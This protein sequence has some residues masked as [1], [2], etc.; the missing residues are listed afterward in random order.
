MLKRMLSP[1]RGEVR[2]QDADPVVEAATVDPHQPKPPTAGF[3]G[4]AICFDGG[5]VRSDP[6][7]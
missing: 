5:L 7:A 6:P 2:G 3:P 4:A 1:P